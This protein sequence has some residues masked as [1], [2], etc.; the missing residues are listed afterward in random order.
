MMLESK[1]K[2]IMKE[3]QS[4]EKKVLSADETLKFL[5]DKDIIS[6]DEAVEKEHK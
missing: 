6:N 4:F 5:N 1:M 2:K 3:K